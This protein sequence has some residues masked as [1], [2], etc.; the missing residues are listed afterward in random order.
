LK[1]QQELWI[2]PLQQTQLPLL[3]CWAA[4]IHKVQG[5]SLDA[6]VIDLGPAMFEDRMECNFRRGCPA[7][8]SLCQNQGIQCSIPGDGMTINFNHQ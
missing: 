4:T 8:F 5:I 2:K 1:A 6:A 3:L 7:Y